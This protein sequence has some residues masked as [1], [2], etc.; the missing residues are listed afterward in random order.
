VPAIR[1]SVVTIA[2]LRNALVIA[3]VTAHVSMELAIAK[4]TFVVWT[5]Q[6]RLVFMTVHLLAFATMVYAIATLASRAKIVL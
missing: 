3:L 1:A 5:V 4:A 6:S 2:A